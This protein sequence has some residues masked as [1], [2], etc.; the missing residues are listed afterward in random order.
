[1]STIALLCEWSDGSDYHV[2][3][4]SADEQL[5]RDDALRRNH[6]LYADRL[7]YWR[8]CPTS[9]ERAPR[10]PDDPVAI[11]QWFVLEVEELTA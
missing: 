1:M 4:W 6:L 5:I 3:G 7:K 9:Y 10:A 8:M 2:R 11:Y